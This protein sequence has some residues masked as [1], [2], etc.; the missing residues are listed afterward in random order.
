VVKVQR[1]PS[2]VIGAGFAS[3]AGR[4]SAHPVE[5]YRNVT[6]RPSWQRVKR[7]AELCEAGQSSIACIHI[8]AIMAR[9]RTVVT[10]ELPEDEARRLTELEIDQDATF[11]EILSELNAAPED[12]VYTGTVHEVPVRPDG[13]A[14]K[15]TKEIFL[16]DIDQSQF[17]GL[18]EYLRDNCGTGTYRVRVKKNG[19]LVKN[20]TLRVKKIGL[21]AVANSNENN[22]LSGI[23]DRLLTRMESLETRLSQQPVPAQLNP[24][25]AMEKMSVVFANLKP[26]DPPPEPKNTMQETLAMVTAILTISKEIGGGGDGGTMWDMIGKVLPGAIEHAGKIL[27]QIQA[28]PQSTPEQ[29]RQQIPQQSQQPQSQ[30]NL[31]PLQIEIQTGADMFGIPPPLFARLRESVILLCRRARSNNAAIGYVDFILDELDDIGQALQ[32][33]VS[34]AETL[35]SQ[36]DLL[37][38][39]HKAF[40][41]TAPYHVWFGEL[42]EACRKEIAGDEC[43]AGLENEPVGQSR[44]ANSHNIEDHAVTDT[45]GKA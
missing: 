16:F 45:G 37:D 14:M 26:R 21:P 42:L 24:F 13:T 12:A 39:M 41:M 3:L 25:E 36:P 8:G 31:S 40:P 7:L 9:T 38:T 4:K 33:P 27:P 6:L 11:S 34:L 29:P 43:D 22:A 44:G 18:N 5:K 2:R 32:L 17:G 15:G 30:P 10:E 1:D 35:L 23:V 19:V 28:Q 20:T